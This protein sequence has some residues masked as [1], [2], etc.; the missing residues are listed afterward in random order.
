MRAITLDAEG[1]LAY[2]LW[3]SYYRSNETALRNT[4]PYDATVE[5]TV[6]GRDSR[7]KGL[8]P[9]A[10]RFRTQSEEED[11]VAETKAPTTS[12]K[13]AAGS[14]SKK[15]VTVDQGFL[16]GS[17][18]T[19]DSALADVIGLEPYFGPP[20][21][22]PALDSAEGVGVPVNLLPPA[23]FPNGVTVTIPCP[24]VN[25]PG[26]LAIYYYDGANWILA[27]DGAG[28]VQPG[29]FGWMVPGSR[30]DYDSYVEIDVYHFSAVITAQTSGTTVT[31]ESD[32]SGCFIS[33]IGGK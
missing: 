31:V 6:D 8:G 12:V 13:G 21:E 7:G 1:N 32:S 20:D 18:I 29:G 9:I 4:Y 2:S 27:C 17:A 15:T 30:H 26:S 24:G 25:D 14:V 10:F 28:N 11:R 5:V 33:A 22:I 3:V 19:Y 23:V 16:K